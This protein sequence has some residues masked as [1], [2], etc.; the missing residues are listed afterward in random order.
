MLIALLVFS[1]SVSMPQKVIADDGRLYLDTNVITSN[2]NSNV[3]STSDFPIKG[4]LFTQEMDQKSQQQGILDTKKQINKI[5]FS[6]KKNSV[7]H[8]QSRSILFKNYHTEP[9]N[10][11]TDNSKPTPVS[12]LYYLL[13]LLSI[14]MIILV[15]Q[16]GKKIAKRK[17]I[18]SYGAHNY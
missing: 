15:Y 11:D 5:N 8:N 16:L 17:V 12:F 10:D 14:P 9:V 6:V 13:I 7:D 3:G 1:L 4:T 18:K 2:S